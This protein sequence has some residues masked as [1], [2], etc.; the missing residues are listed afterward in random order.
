MIGSTYS[1]A[2]SVLKVGTSSGAGTFTALRNI[3]YARS[4]A[5]SAAHAK[6]ARTVFEAQENVDIRFTRIASHVHPLRC[7]TDDALHA[8]RL[9]KLLALRDDIGFHLQP[10]LSSQSVLSER[11]NLHPVVHAQLSSCKGHH[12]IVTTDC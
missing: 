9:Y 8:L 2:C 1:S 3:T 11:L 4:P 5:V 6:I 12:R 10:E 7:Q